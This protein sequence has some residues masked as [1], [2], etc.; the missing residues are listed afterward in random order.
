MRDVCQ[1]E[2]RARLV[3]V[4]EGRLRSELEAEAVALGLGDSV[5]FTGF[6]TD[7]LSL[8]RGFEIFAFPSTHEALGTSVL[9]AMALCKPVVATRAGGIPET[10]QDGITGLLVPPGDPQALAQALCTLLQ[11][12]ERGRLFGE[13]GRRRVEEY[14]TAEHTGA[15]TLRVYCNVL[16]CGS[17]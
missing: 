15:A 9:D 12:P 8:I 7:V 14:F 10:V 1:I 3:I 13:A 2:R 11:N 17:S 5:C 4:G 6:R 16:N